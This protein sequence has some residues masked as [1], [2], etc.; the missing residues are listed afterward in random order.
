MECIV[1]TRSFIL[2]ITRGVELL[3]EVNYLCLAPS[4]FPRW[5]LFLFILNLEQVNARFRRLFTFLLLFLNERACSFKSC[6]LLVVFVSFING[7][8]DLSFLILSFGCLAINKFIIIILFTGV[9]ILA[10]QT[11]LLASVQVSRAISN[12]IIS[13]SHSLVLINNS[14]VT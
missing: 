14:T 6:F 9:V 12:G 4:R 7:I 13:M 8:S 3:S 10:H 2:L 1:V 11:M 5:H